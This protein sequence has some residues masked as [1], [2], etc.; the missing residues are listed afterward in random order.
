MLNASFEH[1]PAFDTRPVTHSPFYQIGINCIF[2]F[3]DYT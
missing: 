2:N 1:P 3:N